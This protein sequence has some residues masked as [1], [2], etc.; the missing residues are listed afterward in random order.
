[1][2][3][4]VA[5]RES[6]EADGVQQHQ[7]RLDKFAAI[8]VGEVNHFPHHERSDGRGVVADVVVNPRRQE[9]ESRSPDAW[10]SPKLIDYKLDRG[11]NR[12]RIRGSRIDGNPMNGPIRC[13]QVLPDGHPGCRLII[14]LTCWGL[15]GW[16]D[17]S[18]KVLLPQCQQNSRALHGGPT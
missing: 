15:G 16:V 7:G 4:T 11:D 6:F 13:E 9:R 18:H 8:G 12:E 17:Y 10:I 3:V 2:V 1:M 14:R 5:I